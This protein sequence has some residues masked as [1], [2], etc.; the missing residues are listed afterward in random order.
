MAG[1]NDTLGLSFEINCIEMIRVDLFCM[2]LV[3]KEMGWS[4]L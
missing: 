4:P 1:K 2:E 3:I